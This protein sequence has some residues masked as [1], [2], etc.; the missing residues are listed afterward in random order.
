MASILSSFAYVPCAFLIR[1][2]ILLYVRSV[3]NWW[4][5]TRSRPLPPGPRALPFVG[6]VFSIPRYKPWLGFRDLSAKY[7]EMTYLEAF[8]QS[9]L[10]LSTPK[11]IFELLEKRSANTSD[12][13][14]TPL[15]PLAGQ[16]YNF[17]FMPYSTFWRRHRRAFWQQFHPDAS[18]KYRSVQRA[19]ARDF[20]AKLLDAPAE[21]RQLIRYNFSGAIMKVVYDAEITNVDDE[22]I[23]IIDE[24]FVG[25]REITVTM[26]VLL[27]L[28]PILGRLP[29][30][31]PGAKF[32]KTLTRS[33]APNDHL[34]HVEFGKSKAI[35][36]SGRAACLRQSHMFTMKTLGSW[37]RGIFCG[38][39]AARANR[40]IQDR[41]G[42]PGR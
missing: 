25:L 39:G 11:V 16:D 8:G 40:T 4:S 41:R 38:L 15:I 5:R 22:R 42:K 30:W 6:N 9:I 37:P 3:I 28:L 7:G 35:V 24:A 27:E 13:L 20:L 18:V 1:L 36:V 12:R 23:N 10:V 14:P 29:S 17:A 32:V 19:Y 34:V 26:Q 2:S 31:M 21:L 33:Q